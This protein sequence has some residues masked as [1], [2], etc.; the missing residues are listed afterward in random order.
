[1]HWV[2]RFME[3]MA[4]LVE[5]HGGVVSDFTGDGLMAWFGVPLIRTDRFEIETDAINTVRCALAMSAKLRAL[6]LDWSDN[7]LPTAR[8]R[9]GICSGEAVVGAYGSRYRLKYAS[10]GTT[11]NT[12]ARLEN[13]DKDGFYQEGDGN[14]ILVSG[15][16]WELLGDRF[17][18][19][20][21][22]EVQLRGLPEPIPVHRLVEEQDELKEQT[23]ATLVGT[24]AM[25]STRRNGAGV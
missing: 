1:M 25:S 2:G 10:V 3:S 24:V 4:E 8:M 14:R 20:S 16:T 9:V 12:A 5:E 18:G 6:N 17:P 15:T 19:I 22:G 13:H 23:E 7:G 11:V 21:L